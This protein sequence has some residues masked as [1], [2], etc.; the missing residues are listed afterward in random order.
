MGSL[1]HAAGLPL[2]SRQAQGAEPL[3]VALVEPDVVGDLVQDGLGH[4][5]PQLSARAA[6]PLVGAL[7]DAD[8]GRSGAGAQPS[9]NRVGSPAPGGPL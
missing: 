7:E 4:L 6:Q 3:E 8:Q 1:V 5:A 2:P 9:S